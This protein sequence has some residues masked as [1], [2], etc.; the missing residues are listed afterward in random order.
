[1]TLT[2]MAPETPTKPPPAA[3]E[4]CLMVSA[5]LACTTTPCRV[6]TLKPVGLLPPMSVPSRTSV[7]EPPELAARASTVAPSAMKACV[8][9]PITITPT[10]APTPTKP[11]PSPPAMIN[12][13]VSSDAETMASP[14]ADTV[15][16]IDAV[17][18]L[19]M[20]STLTP[21]PTPTTPAPMPRPTIRMSSVACASTRTSALAL[22]TAPVPMVEAVVLLSTVT[23]TPGATPTTPKPAP[24][25]S[26][27]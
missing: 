15:P 8:S 12:T 19:L 2:S 21:P 7:A 6:A 5:D 23:S 18:L 25:A 20:A 14:P 13:L 11:A 1:M 9:L 10:D 4:N 22:T 26:A 27:T 16:R 3:T 24:A 17:V